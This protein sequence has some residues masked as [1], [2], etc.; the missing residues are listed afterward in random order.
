M[1]ISASLLVSAPTWQY[2]L[3]YAHRQNYQI[4]GLLQHHHKRRSGKDGPSRQ[5]AH[6]TYR[7]PNTIVAPRTGAA[8]SEAQGSSYRS[9]KSIGAAASVL[10]RTAH[11]LR[12][13][14]TLTTL[15]TRSRG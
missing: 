8:E 13:A 15:S 14:V 6:A 7:L 12:R 2:H 5:G 10:V 11:G 9:R 3:Q 4:A 1:C